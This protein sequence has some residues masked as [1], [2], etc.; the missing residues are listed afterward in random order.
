MM[1]LIT[2]FTQRSCFI[3]LVVLYFF[4]STSLCADEKKILNIGSR[5]EL[6]VDSYL[7]NEL[8]GKA[9]QRLHHPVPREMVI[10]HEEDWE[11]TASGYHSIFKDADL[12]RMYYK[13]WN[14]DIS[15][16]ILDTSKHPLFLCYAESKDG[17]HWIKPNLGIYEYKGSKKNN[18][19]LYPSQFKGVNFDPGH[20]A[21]FK[22]EN[23]NCPPGS[24]YKAFSLSPKP[25]GLIAFHSPDGIHWSPMQ[26]DIVNIVG[27]FDSMNLAF[28]DPI[29][30]EYRA[31]WRIFTG[32]TTTTEVWKPSGI[33]AIKTATSKDFIHWGPAKDLTYVDSPPEQLYTNQIKPYYRAPHLLI[34]FPARYIERDWSQSMRD[35]PQLEDR[36]ERSLSIDRYGMA[37]SETLF[38]VTRNGF[39]FKRWNE[40]FLPPGIERDGTWQYGQQF[41]GW[42]IVETKSSLE[43]NAPNELSIYS[44][45]RYW[46]GKGSCVRRY[47]LRMDGF[48][49]INA[50]REGGELITKPFIF[51]G[52]ELS[53]NFSSSAAGGIKVEIQNPDGTPIK[54]YTLKDNDILFGNSLDRKVTWNEEIDVSNLSG[55][56]IRLRFTLDDANLYSI[57]FE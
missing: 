48:V 22:D 49:S 23:P 53:I 46:K 38:M 27:A 24:Q 9:T 35:L 51:T 1:L 32:G 20:I 37:L 56:P 26:N 11:G 10:K 3:T 45:E 17:I 33:R 13:G 39:H 8:L 21:V 5:R 4:L 55:K 34:G 19:I 16:K 2:S 15:N 31:Y 44:S 18:I 12:Y 28:W 29:R 25:L 7:I 43:G 42:H 14:I 52:K 30:K 40:A 50:P 36:K 41:T 47:T 54:G 57:K 6:F